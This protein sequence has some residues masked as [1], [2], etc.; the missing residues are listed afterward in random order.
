LSEILDKA[1]DILARHSLCNNCLGRQFALLG[2]GTKN[3]GRG[4]A[5]KLLLVMKAHQLALSKEKTGFL[6]LE[7]LA[8]S[9]DF[10]MA[11]DLLSRLGKKE[12]RPLPCYLCSERFESIEKLA[13]LAVDR[14]RIYECN[15]FL[16]GIELPHEV[17]EKE[18]NFKSRFVIEHGESIRSE[19]SRRLGK[20]IGEITGKNTEYQRPEVVILINPFTDEIRLQ[21]NPLYISGR[22]RKLARTIPQ[23]RWFCSKCGGKGCP[24]CDWTGKMYPE[25]VE[26]IIG[27]PALEMSE[28]EDIA[29]HGAGREDIDARML[30]RGRPFVIE[31]KKPRKRFIELR[32]LEQTINE[33]AAGKVEVSNLRFA[34]K[35]VV[36]N[37]K[38]E[39]AQKLYR[40]LV[41]VSDPVSKRQ[42]ALLEKS[43]SGA[44]IKQKTPQ[45]VM[46]RRADLMREKYIY[47]AKVKRLTPNRFE[48]RIQC[49]GGLYIKELITGDGGR[50]MPNVSES[51]KVKA[52][53][54]ELD[55]LGVYVKEET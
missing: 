4:F 27:V 30:G 50:T 9:G 2:Y 24:K 18:D 55:V 46:H 8:S 53:A 36:R 11:N 43:L 34:N 15:S 3:E 29:L 37:F 47:K 13:S 23:S 32:N 12:I 28:G 48:L 19:L 33:R 44:V 41:E 52:V 1:Q 17:E 39:A 31:V 51:L 21:I 7:K 22:Y 16:V 14:L 45:R 35:E 42:L 49:Q 25:S 20:R 10:T 26:E 38:S 40:T 6:M 54:L 5:I